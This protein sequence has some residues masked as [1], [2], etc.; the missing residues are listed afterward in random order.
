MGWLASGI[1]RRGL[2]CLLLCALIIPAASARL[3]ERPI[4]FSVLRSEFP[5]VS[6]IAEGKSACYRI[7]TLL[8]ASAS[9]RA[10]GLMFVRSMP[11]D[12]GM[13]F[14]YPER[15]EMS[16]WMKNTII[17]LDILFA[18][19]DG[20]IVHVAANTTPLSL[21]SISSGGLARYVLELNAG[22]AERL[23]ITVG[24]R[25]HVLTY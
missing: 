10:R 18:D 21:D 17:S 25:L 6:V 24:S 15:R 22:V 1:G 5:A 12:A 11:A 23:G 4:D 7:D 20:D 13:L 2:N 16:M 14:V 9:H 19:D 3:P 8:A